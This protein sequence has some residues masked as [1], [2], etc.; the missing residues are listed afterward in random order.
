MPKEPKHGLAK[1]IPI[2]LTAVSLAS[3]ILMAVI[4]IN[5]VLTRAREISETT[6]AEYYEA[7][8]RSLTVETNRI[9]EYME[10]QTSASQIQFY[11]GIKDKVMDIWNMLHGLESDPRLADYSLES[12]KEIILAVLDNLASADLQNGHF[13][14]TAEGEVLFGRSG[15][16]DGRSSV[17]QGEE[18]EQDLNFDPRLLAQAIESVKTIG[19][20][21]YRLSPADAETG[22]TPVVFLKYYDVYGWIIGASSHYSDYKSEHGEEL[23]QWVNNVPLPPEDNLIIVDFNGDVLANADP[24]AVERNIYE[25]GFI[26]GLREALS[27]VVAQAKDRGRGQI[28]FSLPHPYTGQPTDCVAY[29]RILPSWEWV[30]L[31]WV[32][33]AILEESLAVQQKN[34]RANLSAQIKRALGITLGM[35]ILVAVISLVV[36]RKIGAS[37]SDFTRFF[38]EAA[39]SSV[40]LNPAAQPFAELARM[41]EA[42]NRMIQKRREAERLLHESEVK[43]RTVFDV[44]PQIIAI[45]DIKGHILEVNGAFERYAHCPV[46]EAQGRVLSEAL[47]IPA[48]VWANFLRDLARGDAIRGHEIV[49]DKGGGGAV[50]LLLFGKIMAFMDMEYILGVTVDISE[51]RR[52]EQDKKKLEEKLLSS[53]KME[54]VGLMASSVAHELNNILSGLIGWPELLLR[55]PA[56]AEGHRLVVGDVLEA[57]R[58]AADVVSDLMTVSKGVASAKEAVNLHELTLSVVDSPQVKNAL[59]AFGST[60]RLNVAAPSK[61]P[62]VKVSPKHMKRV[63]SSLLV[64]SIEALSFKEGGGRV[65]VR[66]ENIKLNSNPGSFHKFS[67]GGFVRFSVTDDGPGIPPEAKARIF[68]PFYT[69]KSGSGRGLGLALVEL[70]VREHNGAIEVDSSS[71]GSTFA[72]YMPLAA[73]AVKRKTN[74]AFEELKGQG[75]RILVVD[76]VDIQRKLAQKMLKTLGYDPFSVASGEE[77][78]EYLKSSDADLVILDM[79]MDPGINGRQTYEAILAIKPGQKAIIAS[80]M[81]ENEEVVKA[82]ALGASSFVSKPYSMEDIAGAVFKALHP[83]FS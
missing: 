16:R 29:F 6:T 13:C 72:V 74:A 60:A 40:E 19:E 58:R 69:H 36:S 76:D 57:G 73:E 2:L 49:L 21:F 18:A 5:Y 71:E 75:Q 66:F 56:L 67:P 77:A 7:A 37:V 22:E 55:D 11:V 65:D 78:I 81:A 70:V 39:T 9:A 34:L 8:E 46:A 32:D 25:D 48:D 43:F 23:L 28:G 4:W 30:V 61:P 80:G 15:R 20:G 54:A 50:N 14:L 27:A 26:P 31:T 38:S 3:I 53:Q 51:L 82:Q 62:I 68:E 47:N 33:S 63:V 59:T 83:D 45:M 35:L 41:A 1:V 79:I 42:A 24:V 64:N 12:S 17:G 44:S 10:A 52:A